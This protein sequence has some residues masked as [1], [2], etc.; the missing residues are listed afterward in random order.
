MTT[1]APTEPMFVALASILAAIESGII[2][3]GEVQ[4]RDDHLTGEVSNEHTITITVR[5]ESPSLYPAPKED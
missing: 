2:A 4:T 1:E 3:E 5:K